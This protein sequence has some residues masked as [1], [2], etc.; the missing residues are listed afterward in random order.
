MKK[1]LSAIVFLLFIISVVFVQ[2]AYAETIAPTDEKKV[3]KK[4]SETFVYIKEGGKKYHKKNCTLV[5]TGKTQITMGEALK[6]GYT[7]CKICIPVFVNANG[8]K[9]HQKGCSMIKEGATEMT[10]SDAVKAEYTP[11]KICI[12]TEEEN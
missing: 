4:L 2:P 12:P 3:E 9:Y 5:K 10:I 7:P 11:C 6:K 1:T 8:K